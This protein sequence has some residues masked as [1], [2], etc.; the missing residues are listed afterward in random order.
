MP[1]VK[2]LCSARTLA[3]LVDSA[4]NPVSRW[5]IPAIPFQAPKEP[6]FSLSCGRWR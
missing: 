4:Q 6:I 2:E 5:D 3:K 1:E